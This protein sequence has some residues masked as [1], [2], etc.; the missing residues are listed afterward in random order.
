MI[1]AS[2]PIIVPMYLGN[3]GGDISLSAMQG[4]LLACNIFMIIGYII[5]LLLWYNQSRKDAG[6][7]FCEYFFDIDYASDTGLII[8]HIL[9]I[10]INGLALLFWVASLC[11]ELF[12]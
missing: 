2:Y 5:Y 12:K 8:N 6:Y 4:L 1:A 10:F 9:F 11:A 7:T 3:G